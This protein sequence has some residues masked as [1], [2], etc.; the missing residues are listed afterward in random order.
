MSADASLQPTLWRTC[1][2]LA[3]RTRLKLFA[4]LLRHPRQSVSA[5][6]ATLKQPLPVASEYLR[7]LEAR[8]LLTVRRAGRHV[9]Y[10][11]SAASDGTRLADL[12]IALRGVFRN[13]NEPEETVF[14]LVTAFTHPRRIQIFQHVQKQALT[15]SELQA[16]AHIPDRALHR[17]L[18]KL[19]ARGFV[20]SEC[21]RYCAARRTDAL[22]RELARL[23]AG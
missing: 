1:R 10:H 2:V 9:T 23:A 6:A 4:L 12:I 5:L 20:Q 17:H 11:P 8:G 21:G 13:Q 15:F 19:E 18:R 16:S 14:K 7:M 3:N 22:G